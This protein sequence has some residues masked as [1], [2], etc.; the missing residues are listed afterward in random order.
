MRTEPLL[1]VE[2]DPNAAFM[3]LQVNHYQYWWS[4][5][6]LALCLVVRVMD[7]H[8]DTLGYVWGEWEDTGVMAFHGCAQHGRKLPLFTSNLFV[9]LCDLAFACGAD[10]LTTN[11][12]LSP[13]QAALRRLHRRLGLEVGDDEDTLNLWNLHGQEKVRR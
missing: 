13:N 6:D 2:T 4:P 10:E 12:S 7:A 8:G 3:F 1:R 11:V 9:R 5:E